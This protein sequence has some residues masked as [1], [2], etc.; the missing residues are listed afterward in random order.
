M[1]DH[2]RFA[3]RCFKLRRVERSFADLEFFLRFGDGFDRF[4]AWNNFGYPLSDRICLFHLRP[5]DRLLRI[6]QPFSDLCNDMDLTSRAR[7]S[8]RTTV[9][10]SN[11]IEH[12]LLCRRFGLFIA[13]QHRQN[14]RCFGE[15]IGMPGVQGC[16]QHH[17]HVKIAEGFIGK[18][19][20]RI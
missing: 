16:A 19:R 8:F 7:Q 10:Q 15:P 14:N 5:I 13:C 1:G 12:R 3:T 9:A 20:I 6:K 2:L 17:Q 11:I 4:V 18:G